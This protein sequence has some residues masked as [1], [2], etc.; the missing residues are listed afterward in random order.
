MKWSRK[1]IWLLLFI[2]LLS[3]G[4]R[5]A[6]LVHL[7]GVCR[8]D[9]AVFGLMTK[10]LIEGKGF[11]IYLYGAHYA[12][13]LLC[14]LAAP[15]FFLFGVSM[16]VLKLTTYLFMIPTVILIYLL[17]RALSDRKVAFL[18]ALFM[19]V[20]PFLINWTGQYAGGGY[21]ET[22][23]FGALSLLLT[24]RL[25]FTK[26]TPTQEIRSLALLG[27]VNG[28]GTWILFS[29]IPYT[30][31]A[32]TFIVSKKMK[33]SLK[34][35]LTFFWVFYAVGISPLVIYNVRYPFATFTRLGS[36]VTG[37][38]KGDVAGR[39]IGDLMH[40][41]L[42]T[43]VWMAL[44]LPKAIFQIVQ[45]V[46]DMMRIVP[47]LGGMSAVWNILLVFVLASLFLTVVFS[48]RKNFLKSP[49]SLL[50]VLVVWMVFFLAITGLTKTRYV[51]FMY[52]ALAI[53]LAWSILQAT[54]RRRSWFP[55]ATLFLSANLLNHLV[56][57]K[58][59]EFEDRF[60]ELVAFLEAKGLRYGYTDYVTAYP[61]VFL[62]REKILCSP[63]AGPL[64]VERVPAYTEKVN[65]AKEVFFIFEKDSEA[66]RQFEEALKARRVSFRKEEAGRHAVYDDL[67]KRVHPG[68]LPLV[69]FFPVD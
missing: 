36:R 52:P 2:L 58:T 10:H 45:N 40:L 67:S 21:P 56:V 25:I 32:W 64:N 20:P 3:F 43:A 17:A 55:L 30:V 16:P 6:Y 35:L 13:A 15:L 11:P 59:P 61:V 51:S 54:L 14:Y 42:S 44:E 18:S 65:Q 23:F 69:R 31:T 34:K 53:L 63:T 57:L 47:S 29:M 27:F 66:S 46:W 7:S 48:Q 8:A 60:G 41:G 22:L 12:G 50:S 38:E 1:E 68:D 4:I 28:I 9:E 19:A 26:T 33:N 39:G 24:H 37:I 5:L 62:T 49:L